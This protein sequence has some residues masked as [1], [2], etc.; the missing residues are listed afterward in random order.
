MP[1]KSLKTKAWFIIICAILCS[2]CI[3][4]AA[5]WQSLVLMAASW[6]V[7]AVIIVVAL[8]ILHKDTGQRYSFRQLAK[9]NGSP[10]QNL[11]IQLW[12]IIIYTITCFSLMGIFAWLHRPIVTSYGMMIF[13]ICSAVRILYETSHCENDIAPSAED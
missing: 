5:I 10:E 1:Y 4:G 2:V 11:H 9:P 12:A 6:L 3:I 8:S 13:V 7:L